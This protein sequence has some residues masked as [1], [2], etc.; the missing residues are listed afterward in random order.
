MDTNNNSVENQ[1][2][3]M[4]KQPRFLSLETDLNANRDKMDPNGHIKNLL[5]LRDL[6][7]K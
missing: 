4:L 2:L 1:E 7:L 3:S 6:M 5:S